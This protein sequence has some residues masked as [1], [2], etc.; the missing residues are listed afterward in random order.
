M[1]RCVIFAEKNS[2]IYSD[3]VIYLC[4]D[5]WVMKWSELRRI[6]EEYGW[7]KWR[8]GANHDIYRHPDRKGVLQIA[9]HGSEEV[10]TGT[11]NKLKKQ[12]GF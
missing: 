1:A 3:Y 12:I 5:T 7:R 2:W 8:S 10:K 4:C 11:F 6:A 9:R